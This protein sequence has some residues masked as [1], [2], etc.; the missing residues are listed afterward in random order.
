M[1]KSAAQKFASMTTYVNDG[2]LNLKTCLETVR[3]NLLL[4]GLNLRSMSE[5][6]SLER[7]AICRHFD[8]HVNELLAVILA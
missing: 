4:I 7:V 3:C 8:W 6:E 5:L 2:E 1:D